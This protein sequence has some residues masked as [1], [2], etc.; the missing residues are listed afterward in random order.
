[1]QPTP[2]LTEQAQAEFRRLD[3]LNQKVSLIRKSD[4]FCAAISRVWDPDAIARND[5]LGTRW[6][7]FVHLHDLQRLLAWLR[8]SSVGPLVYRGTGPDGVVVVSLVKID[9]GDWTLCG[10][11]CRPLEPGDE[12]IFWKEFTSLASLTAATFQSAPIL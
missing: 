3:Q 12:I 4:G 8:S 10:G 9:Y 7:E 1:M 2:S 6:H 11:D 5:I